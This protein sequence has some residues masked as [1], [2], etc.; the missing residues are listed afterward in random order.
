[1]QRELDHAP[2][3]VT[4]AAERFEA[5]VPLVPGTPRGRSTAPKRPS[6]GRGPG[7]DGPPFPLVPRVMPILATKHAAL[8]QAGPGH[9]GLEIVKDDLHGPK[10][11]SILAICKLFLLASGMLPL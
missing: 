2:A 5:V 1:M 8:V 4:P 10:L 11:P 3:I 7:G 6:P 9:G